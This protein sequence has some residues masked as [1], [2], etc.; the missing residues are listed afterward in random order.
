MDLTD[1]CFAG[2]DHG[3]IVGEIGSVVFRTSDAG[4]TW[5]PVATGIGQALSSVQT[6]DGRR[7]WAV[8]ERGTRLNTSDAGASW[9]VEAAAP[10]WPGLMYVSA[11]DHHVNGLA[12][13]LAALAIDHEVT[14]VF[15]LG[16]PN[17][18]RAAAWSIAAWQARP[19]REFIG[20][21]RRA[22]GRLHHHYQTKQGLEPLERRLVALIRAL[23]PQAVLCEWPIMDEGYWAG[24]P[25]FT[26]RAAVRAFESA[27][28]PGA[29]AELGEIGLAP[30]QASRLYH[31]GSFFNDLYRVHPT[32]VTL[33]PKDQYSPVLGMHASEAAFRQSCCWM[34]LLD[35]RSG[36]AA[37][38][39]LRLH[40]KREV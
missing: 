31:V 13:V 24:E 10:E 6:V 18:C 12:G 36:R 14:C 20:G 27:A 26:A 2:P 16:V 11:H 22:P 7:I 33:Q 32:N 25:A 3:W 38:G 29:F 17:A 15:A 23:R 34:G 39:S 1:L 9:Q 30:W 40:L 21:R 28:D 35:R 8:G 37:V 19:C 4:R 5:E